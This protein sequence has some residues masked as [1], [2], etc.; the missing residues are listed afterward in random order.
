MPDVVTDVVRCDRLLRIYTSSQGETHALRGVDAS[1]RAGTVTAVTGPSGSGKTS[2]LSVVGLQ[3]RQD[4]GEL[5]VLGRDVGALTE[6]ALRALRRRR[7]AW[8]AQR[9]SEC[10][11]PHLTAREHVRQV[12]LLRG[13]GRVPADEPLERLGLGSRRAAFPRQ[14]SGG[15]QQRLAVALAGV[16]RPALVVADEPTAEL[17]DA[18][19]ALVL[20]ELRGCAEEGA[21]VVLAT[22]DARV[23]AAA[24]RVLALR[25]GVL[26]SE[27]E[28]DGVT[29]AS[30]DS[31]G[32][33]QLPPEALDLFPGGRAVVTL[34]DGG[35]LLRP[36]PDA[37]ESR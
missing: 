17:D 18:T 28:R 9:P 19:S 29:T 6:R 14:L 7:V 23:V 27:R 36:L 26:S 37:Q 3:E 32:R 11:F 12:G 33:L 13:A 2:L 10:L 5:R 21:A 16:G 24:D 15:E 31:T 1:F 25:H 34:E 22:H 4:G 35:V 20:A 30:I 8:V